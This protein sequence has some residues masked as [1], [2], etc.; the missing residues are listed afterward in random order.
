[1]AICGIYKITNTINNKCYIGQSIDIEKRFRQHKNNYDNSNE[2]SYDAHFYRAIRKHGIDNFKFE[3]I[4]EC[5]QDRLD[6]REIFWI[7]YYDSFYNGYNSTLGGDKGLRVDRNKFKNYFIQNNPSVTEIAE[8]FDI[9]RSVAG[10]I[11][12]EL[13]LKSLYYVSEEKEKQICN[14]Y[15]SDTNLTLLDVSNKFNIDRDTASKVLKRNNIDVRKI[16]TNSFNR[17]KKI[18]IYDLDGNFIREDLLSN[19]KQWLY[20]NGYTK[21]KNGRCVMRCLRGDGMQSNGFIIRWHKDNYPLKIKTTDYWDK[22]GVYEFKKDFIQST[23]N[24]KYKTLHR[25]KTLNK[26]LKDIKILMYNVKNGIFIKETTF[27]LEINNLIEQGKGE[28]KAKNI[29]RDI[30][31]GRMKSFKGCVY[32]HYKNNYPKNIDTTKKWKNS[33]WGKENT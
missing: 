13:G 33:Y 24:K 5:E 16:T 27:L 11:L 15:L 26:T 2:L 1:M 32:R 20:E 22:N 6:E 9:D 28:E 19:F 18:L 4:E 30:L 31:S 12:K 23:V 21:D 10:R 8:H 29:I 17:Y 25:N 14:Y 3:I 7:D